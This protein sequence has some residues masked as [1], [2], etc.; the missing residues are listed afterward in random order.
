MSLQSSKWWLHLLGVDTEGMPTDAVVESVWLNLPYSLQW[1]IVAVVVAIGAYLIFWMYRRE[2]DTCPMWA[3]MTLDSLRVASFILLLVIVF[4]PAIVHTKRNELKPS[5]FI[6]RDDSHSMAFKDAYLSDEV[7]EHAANALG[8]SIEELRERHPNR[9]EVL[10]AALEND[11]WKFVGDLQRRGNLRIVNFH[12]SVIPVGQRKPLSDLKQEAEKQQAEDPVALANSLRLARIYGGAA[13]GLLIA[14]AVCGFFAWYASSINTTWL[15]GLVATTGV[16]GAVVLAGVN[17]LYYPEI[18]VTQMVQG[19]DLAKQ[20]TPDAEGEDKGPADAIRPLPPL[21]ASG[22]GSNIHAVLE[23][24]LRERHTAAA[25]IFTDGRNTVRE[26]TRDK[27]VALA[28]QADR[29]KE[30]R[31]PIFFVG[32]GDPN[33]PRNLSISD[34]YADPQVFPEEPFEIRAVVR[35]QDV[36]DRPVRV[37]L[38]QQPMN[39]DGT[40]AG[41]PTVVDTRTDQRIPESGKLDLIFKVDAGKPGLYA[42]TVRVEKIDNES[43]VD[44]NEPKTPTI[45]KVL[46]DKAKVL[47]VAGAPTWEYRMVQRLLSREDSVELKC[48]LQTLDEDRAQEGNGDLLQKLPVDKKELFNFDVIMMFDPDPIEFDPA[49][50]DLLKDFV[51][52]HAGGV[53]YMAGPKFSGRFLGAPRTRTMRDVL[54]VRMGDVGAMEVANLLET[55]TRAFPLD[56]VPSNVDL[57]IMRFESDPQESLEQWGRMPGIYWSFPSEGPKPASR[58][59]IQHGDEIVQG[60]SES[61]NRPLLVTGQYGSG[62]TIYMGFNGT[63]RWRKVGH[64]AEYYKRLWIQ[65]TRYLI[66]GRSL[67]G[68]RRGSVEVNKARY[69]LGDRVE[70][71]ARDLKDENF[72]LYVLKEIPVEII[73]DGEKPRTMMLKAVPNQEGIYQSSFAVRS[74]GRHI[75]KVKMPQ[76]TGEP[77]TVQTA[78]DV[79]LPT[80]ET[81]EVALNKPL[82]VEL[83]N[84]SGG[85]YFEIDE[86]ANLPSKIPPKI[87]HS[88]F[89]DKP[90]LLWDTNRLLLL[91]VALLSVEWAMRKGFKLL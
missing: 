2:L 78:F 49:W 5:I 4:Q 16:V 11:E 80:V 34:V 77:P 69:P 86:I 85:A 73:S 26:H 23:D 1:W 8:T 74:T 47:L 6:A 67:E 27:L 20:E 32:V 35:G 55:N 91:L 25:V 64:N 82:L 62:R 33:R 61:G 89:Q 66:E 18:S 84:A 56:V 10:N 52:E 75:V 88:E 81:N 36:G 90:R 42:Y 30:D 37:D 38:L 87:R 12:N 48:W 31:V 50:I 60:L 9:V 45:V 46:D 71:T 53:L 19:L 28:A 51:G 44:D 29:A 17:A 68:R 43:N 21:D 65:T 54:P 13:A 63:W 58:V 22:Q 15:L 70:I 59:L 14:A 72:N 40:S 24:A 39:A 57:P 3:K 83:A 79:I 7:A 76:G 41:E